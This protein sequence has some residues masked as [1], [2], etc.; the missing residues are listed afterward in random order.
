MHIG[1]EVDK[2][3]PGIDPSSFMPCRPTFNCP[4]AARP[5]VKDYCA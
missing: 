4:N 2:Q 5:A 3:E 1:F